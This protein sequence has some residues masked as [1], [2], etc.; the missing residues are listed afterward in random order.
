MKIINYEDLVF[1][2]NESQ[3]KGSF[4]TIKK[5]TLD[6]KTYAYKEF[7]F[8]DYLQGK[9]RK[10]DLLSNIDEPGLYVP[11]FWVRK[12]ENTNQYLTDY[13]DAKDIDIWSSEDNKT[14]FIMLNKAKNKI[15]R[16]HEYN[17]IHSDL[18]SSNIMYNGNDIGIVDFD[19][20]N[21]GK[22]KTKFIHSNDLTQDFLLQYGMRKELDI[23]IFN[24]STFAIMNNLKSFY[25][26]RERV[27]E[28]LYGV[29]N[30]PD[31]RKICDSFFMDSDIPNN[32]FLID[33]I[34]D[35]IIM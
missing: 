10:I 21:F 15:L 23:F 5:C 24:L 20:S 35:T 3:F 6:G 7:F 14:K 16:M 12:D 25:F 22:Y 29:F 28:K 2:E 33:T 11:K 9:K 19:N 17:L 13:F 18:I 34:E 4:G 32:D 27:R 30:N 26:T 8:P 1:D 31:G